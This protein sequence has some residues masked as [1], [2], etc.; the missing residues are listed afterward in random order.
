LV[1]GSF[2]KHQINSCMEHLSPVTAEERTHLT[3]K[4]LESGYRLLARHR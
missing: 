2:E 3:Q 1:D 4:E